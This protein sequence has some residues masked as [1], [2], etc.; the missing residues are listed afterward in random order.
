MEVLE[1]EPEI[2]ADKKCDKSIS[3]LKYEHLSYSKF[4][5]QYLNANWPVILTNVSN[6][7]E[8]RKNW[9]ISTENNMQINFEYLKTKIQNCQVPVADCDTQYFNSHSKKEMQ[10]FDFLDYWK[11]KSLHE[12][13]ENTNNN[14]QQNLYLKDWHLRAQKPDYDFYKV[15]KYFASDWLNEQLLSKK[16]DDYCF[17]YMGPK[18]TWWVYNFYF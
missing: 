1:L 4:Y 18:G 9:M 14:K 13:A 7:W 10:F 8:C 12:A 16:K 3:R 11:Q 15:P 2:E 17:V 5:W 6:E